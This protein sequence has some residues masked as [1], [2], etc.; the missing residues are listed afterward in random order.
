MREEKECELGCY[1]HIYFLHDCY[2]KIVDG[3][4]KRLN[5][6]EAEEIIDLT[7]F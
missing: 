7:S 1:R 2:E 3:E 6:D 4:C 5:P